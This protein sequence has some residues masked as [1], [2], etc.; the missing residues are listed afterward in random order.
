M[1]IAYQGIDG[2]YEYHG[3]VSIQYK[4]NENTLPFRIE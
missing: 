2:R 1:E 3:L 4:E